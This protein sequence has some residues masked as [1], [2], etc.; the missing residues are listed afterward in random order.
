MAD[1]N[2]GTGGDLKSVT[3]EAAILELAQ[4]IQAAEIAATETIDN[5]SLTVNTDAETA[6]IAVTLPVTVTTDATGKLVIAAVPY[7]P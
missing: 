6:S 5:I 2:P 1:F 3:P 4:I 7:L